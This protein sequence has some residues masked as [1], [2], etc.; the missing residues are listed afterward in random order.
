MLTFM[1]L[2]LFLLIYADD[3]IIN[4]YYYTS[5]HYIKIHL[6]HY[7]QSLY[8]GRAFILRNLSVHDLKLSPK[9]L[10]Y[11]E[12]FVVCI[13]CNPRD[14]DATLLPR[15]T[16]FTVKERYCIRVRSGPLFILA[17][18]SLQVFQISMLQ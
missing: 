14:H 16:C 10:L 6:I 2:I 11:I 4:Y 17:L 7:D 1:S 13:Y 15:E 3:T 18:G 9:F 5:T 12:L 8:R